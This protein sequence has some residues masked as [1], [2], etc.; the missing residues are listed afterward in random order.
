LVLIG[1]FL[2]QAAR[3]SWELVRVRTQLE[4][5]RV[6]EI[7]TRAPLST[8]LIAPLAEAGAA[9]GP[10]QVVR[11]AESAWSAFVKLGRTRGGRLAVVDGGA[12][13]G[14]VTHRDLQA[15]LAPNGAG[16]SPLARRAA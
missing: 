2:H 4:P 7:M 15:A 10:E 9:L 13:V 3:S 16:P 12:L 8:D 6:E 14:V 5:L 1:L 11:P